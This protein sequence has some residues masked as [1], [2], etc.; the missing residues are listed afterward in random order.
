MMESA[1]I[2]M[3]PAHAGVPVIR[4]E[5]TSG[6][7]RGEVVIGQRLG[8]L[9]NE[10]D[11]SGGLDLDKAH[12]VLE[13]SSR[14]RGPMIGRVASMTLQRG[15]S[16]ETKLDPAFQ[17]F[18]R[19]HQIEGTP[20]LPGVMGI[21]A[22]A[23]AALCLLP[24][25][26]IESVENVDFLAPVKFYR[27]EPRTL[28]IEALVHPEGDVLVADCRLLGNRRLVNQPD[29]QVTT[30]FTGRVS[31][32]R[33]LSVATITA[34][35]SSPAKALITAADVYR[36]Y[37]H[38]PAYQVVERAWWDGAR[39]VAEL[40]RN[41][42]ANHHP[43][44]LASAVSPRLIEL[45]FQAA[46]LWGLAVEGQLGLPQHVDY[47]RVLRAPELVVGGLYAV[48]TP[49]AQPAQFNVEVIDTDGNLYVQ[50]RGYRTVAL[51]KDIDAKALKALQAPVSL[52]TAAA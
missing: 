35:L 30:H 32:A 9:L 39:M 33:E 19:D 25:W 2:D 38:G 36:V 22:F 18:L 37:F 8:V 12:A 1:G 27:N 45:C 40:A 6:G 41:L 48:V 17:P 16:I 43:P 44:E 23:E 46:G 34:K 7:T 3:L 28:T 15:L 14:A 47:V 31:L 24:N 42:P 26:H 51:P 49:Q 13:E 50:L 20:L 29:L 10:W 4:R 5:L 11:V 21:E 52:Q